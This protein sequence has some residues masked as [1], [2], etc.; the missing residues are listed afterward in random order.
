MKNNNAVPIKETVAAAVLVVVLLA[1]VNPFSW[2]MPSMMLAGLLVISLVAFGLF[3]AFIVKEKTVDEREEQHKVLAGRVAFI[4]GT[5]VLT[6]AIVVQS[7]H[8]AVDPWLY[9]AFVAMVVSK[10]LARA[11]TDRNF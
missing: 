3:A 5:A 6:V 11:Y 9:V 2:W 7:L 1:L 4:T 10:L 8:H